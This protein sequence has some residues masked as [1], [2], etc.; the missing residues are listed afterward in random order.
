MVNNKE[1]I[2][3]KEKE[4]KEMQEM[5]RYIDHARN[6]LS[7]IRVWLEHERNRFQEQIIKENEK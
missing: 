3:K 7:D 4:K 6:V 5:V 2:Q 1:T